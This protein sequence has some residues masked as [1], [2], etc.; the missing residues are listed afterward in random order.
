MRAT[1]CAL[2][3]ALARGVAFYDE[4]TQLWR[5]ADVG[6]DPRWRAECSEA[7][8]ASS[9]PGGGV[10]K[11]RAGVPSTCETTTQRDSRDASKGV[12]VHTHFLRR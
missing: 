12:V 6:A 8:G 9:T 11:P 5:S 7:W 4:E 10:S 3:C 1:V 2:A